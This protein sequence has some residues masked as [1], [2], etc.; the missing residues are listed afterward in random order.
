MLLAVLHL[1]LL[2]SVDGREIFVNPEQVTSV[3]GYTD[4]EHNKV[5]A[6][7][8]NCVIGMTN[9]K[10]ISV[11]EYCDEVKQKLEDAK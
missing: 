6:E 7:S 9:G 4:G 11:A 5:L 8:V 2:H 1:V 3:Q 10:F